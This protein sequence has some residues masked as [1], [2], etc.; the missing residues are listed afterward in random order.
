VGLILD[1][2]RFF[3]Y[4]VAE[5]YQTLPGLGNSLPVSKNWE[6]ATAQRNG[7]KPME[8]LRKL[9][10]KLRAGKITQEQYT[11][12]LKTLLD[13]EDVS[14]EEYDD[15]KGFNPEKEKDPPIYTQADLEAYAQK[16]IT[17]VVMK[18]TQTKVRQIC[19]A[20]D[21]DVTDVPNEKLLDH[22]TG[23]LKSGKGKKAG[24]DDNTEDGGAK[25]A[26]VDKLRKQAARVPELE[27]KVKS[28]TVENTVLKVAAK[29]NPVNPAQVSRAILSDYTDELEYDD[30]GI[31]VSK[32]VEKTISR[33]AKAEPNLFKKK[34]TDGTNTN[35]EEEEEE[36]ENP[37]GDDTLKGKGPDGGSGAASSGAKTQQ[38]VNS[39]LDMLGIKPTKATD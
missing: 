31:L 33:V 10:A 28:L 2:E 19:N 37:G 23:L 20:A 1:K 15:A 39:G 35:K 18:K 22:V 26:E 7:G 13:N 27:G 34:N 16:E 36:E 17:R 3:C 25:G 29:F 14:Q 4:T 30:E 5:K 24:T 32:S 8:V 9:Q 12:Q 21:I 11:A 38:L 6:R